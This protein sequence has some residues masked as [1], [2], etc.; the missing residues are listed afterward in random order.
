MTVALLTNC[1]FG[2]VKVIKILKLS[3]NTDVLG[4]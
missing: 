1:L 2:G 4:V 3:I